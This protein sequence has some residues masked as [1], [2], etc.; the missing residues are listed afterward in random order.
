MRALPGSRDS[1]SLAV[2]GPVSLLASVM[3]VCALA[4][5]ATVGTSSMTA[6]RPAAPGAS[7][8]ASAK[9][10]TAVKPSPTPQQRAIAD[11][12][13]IF[14]SFPVPPGARKFASP[15]GLGG[16]LVQRMLL[17]SQPQTDVVDTG[18]WWEAPGAPPAVLKWVQA[19]QPS[20]FSQADGGKSWARG[21][22]TI[23][24]D[25]FSLPAVL[26]L[27]DNR[28]LMVQA[29]ADGKRT[30]LR[31]D[32]QV[33]WNPPRPASEVVPSAARVVT[34][35]MVSY[36]GK[37][38]RPPAPVTI[39]DPGKVRQIIALTNGLPLSPFP[40]VSCLEGDAGLLWL[41]FRATAGGPA[42][43]VARVEAGGCGGVLF[44]IRG[45]FQPELGS[46][47]PTAEFGLQVLRVAGLHWNVGFANFV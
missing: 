19:H 21:A 22:P 27:L 47:G 40:P 26:G 31:V 45:K 44:S 35:S 29:V 16:P 46:L 28:D 2:P 9:A 4:G 24:F 5:C 15:P 41:T 42:L 32:A 13:A 7:A 17:V 37:S 43:A 36:L 6:A 33:T 8:H 23:T 39:S 20:R 34:L 12:G 38:G 18:G 1:R 14:A 25:T 11:A 3:A 30:A 10:S